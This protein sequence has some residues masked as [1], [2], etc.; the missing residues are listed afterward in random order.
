[1][2]KLIDLTGEAVPVQAPRYCGEQN[3]VR[4]TPTAASRDIQYCEII[5]FI[6]EF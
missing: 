1:M 5:G 2:P 3:E 4:G 6:A